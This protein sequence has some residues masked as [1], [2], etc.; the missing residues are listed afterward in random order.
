MAPYPGAFNIRG[1][2]G[3]SAQEQRDHRSQKR[4]EDNPSRC[5]DQPSLK[6]QFTEAPNI[7]QM[8]EAPER[9]NRAADEEQ[10]E[11]EVQRAAKSRND[12]RRIRLFQV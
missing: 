2:A 11:H 10:A 6:F 7:S 5:R 9:E 12:R 1:S 3:F 8:K 4:E